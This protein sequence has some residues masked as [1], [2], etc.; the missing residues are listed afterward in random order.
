MLGN[1]NISL[2]EKAFCILFSFRAGR[3]LKDKAVLF[4]YCVL[5]FLSR[6]IRISCRLL[7][8]RRYSL[9]PLMLTDVVVR[10]HDVSYRCRKGTDD[11]SIILSP[12]EEPLRRFIRSNLDKGIF[13]D[14]G[15]HVGLYTIF[16]G[17]LLEGKGKVIAIEP[18]PSNFEA[19]KA[20]IK[21]NELDNVISLNVAADQENKE[22]TLFCPTKG[23]S[24]SWSSLLPQ[25]WEEGKQLSIQAIK[26]DDIVAPMVDRSD[27]ILVKIDVEGVEERVIRGMKGILQTPNIQILFEVE[28]DELPTSLHDFLAEMRFCVSH[29]ADSV[30]WRA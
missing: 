25:Q 22:V 20:N 15:A 17:K 21:L 18:E 28:A 9:K 12:M 26:L 6:L 19:L 13:I 14:I 23:G 8:R 7:F 10:T 3:S 4:I 27:I 29:L 11:A 5:W 30:M 16:A 2:W 24:T 1:K